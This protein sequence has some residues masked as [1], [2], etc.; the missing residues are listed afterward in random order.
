MPVPALHAS[1]R[2][3]S[4]PLLVPLSQSQGAGPGSPRDGLPGAPG[5]GPQPGAS[6]MFIKCLLEEWQVWAEARWGESPG[7]L[8]HP[9]TSQV[10]TQAPSFQG[11]EHRRALAIGT[12]HT[13]PHTEGGNTA[14]GQAWGRK[15]PRKQHGEEIFRKRKKSEKSEIVTQAGPCTGDN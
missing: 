12:A 2:S 3:Q 15:R 11:S 9:S 5:P 10:L 6:L 14:C 1:L 13:H 8:T 4:C 7:L